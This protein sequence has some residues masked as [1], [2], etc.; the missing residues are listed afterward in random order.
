MP[1]VKEEKYEIRPLTD[2]Q[3]NM[4]YFEMLAGIYNP[5]GKKVACAWWNSCLAPGIRRTRS[6]L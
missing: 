3:M 5:T 2:G 4:Y 1:G 6:I